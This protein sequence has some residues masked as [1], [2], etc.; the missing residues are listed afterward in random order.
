MSTR[1]PRYKKVPVL[2]IR[3]WS[4]FPPILII[5]IV[6]WEAWER[7][8]VHRATRVQGRKSRKTYMLREHAFT[9]SSSGESVHLLAVGGSQYEIYMDD[10]FCVEDYGL[11][12]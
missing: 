4:P 5:Y 10:Y 2:L 1:A 8:A 3:G 9:R 7:P 12:S 6:G 11:L